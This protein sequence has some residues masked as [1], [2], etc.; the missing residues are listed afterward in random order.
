VL[1]IARFSAACMGRLR[2]LM[3]PRDAG[4]GKSVVSPVISTHAS[5]LLRAMMPPVSFVFLPAS[6]NYDEAYSPPQYET[7]NIYIC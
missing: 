3:L 5:G 6:C 7:Y 2:L 4:N 1:M